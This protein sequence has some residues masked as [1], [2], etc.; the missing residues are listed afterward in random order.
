MFSFV[1]ILV[2]FPLT[3]PAH[4]LF[5]FLRLIRFQARIVGED[6][7]FTPLQFGNTEMVFHLGWDER[8][9]PYPPFPGGQC[10]ARCRGAQTL[11]PHLPRRF[12]WEGVSPTHSG[13]SESQTKPQQEAHA[14]PHC[15]QTLVVISVVLT[16]LA[17]RPPQ[18]PRPVL[19]E[20]LRPPEA[21]QRRRCRPPP[22]LLPRAG[23]GPPRLAG[24]PTV[25]RAGVGPAV[26]E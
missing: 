11:L 1:F 18:P 26:A 14:R 6:F 2:A 19:R 12:G 23:D 13:G 7:R 22:A 4:F 20:L 10:D 17:P 21:G 25:P 24:R 8:V 15:A 3:P 16:S 5:I 9:S